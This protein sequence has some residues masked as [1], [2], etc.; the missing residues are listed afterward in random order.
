[1]C[2][3]FAFR[4]FHNILYTVMVTD[5]TRNENGKER[6]TFLKKKEKENQNND[7]VVTFH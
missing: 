1:M 3:V 5:I 2:R 7:E 4:V 6:K